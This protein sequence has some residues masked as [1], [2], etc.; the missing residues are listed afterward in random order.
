MS[1]EE[2]LAEPA[3]LPYAHKGDLTQGDIGRHLFNM[4]APMI[5]GLLAVISIQLADTYFISLLGTQE[6]AAISFTFPVT[7]IITHLV[8]GLNIALSSVISRLLGARDIHTAQ[9]VT[10]HGLLLACALSFIVALITFIFLEPL[11]LLLGA[12]DTTMPLINQFM[13]IWL[14]GSVLLTIPVISNSAM[15]AAGDS[16][17]PMMVMALMALVNII[18]NPIL[19]FGWFGLPTLGIMGSAVSTCLAYA[20]AMVLSLY[21]LIRVKNLLPQDGLYLSQIGDS[22]RRL[23]F[24]A[25]PAGITNIVQPLTNAVITALLAAHGAHAVAAFGVATRVEA[26]AMLLV[27]A[28]ALGLAPIVG[29]NWGA[30]NFP[31]VHRAITLSIRFNFFWSALVALILFVFAEPV[32]RVF[33]EDADVVSYAVWYFLLVPVSYGLSNLVFGWGAAFNAMGLPQWSF[34]MIAVKA[35]VITL[36]AVVIG[37]YL[38]D[39]MGILIALSLANILSGVVFHILSWRIC[40][41]QEEKLAQ[42]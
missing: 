6:L 35:F 12:D 25:I 15:R 5:G 36:P 13:P 31:R 41:Q 38:G 3:P 29:Q 42:A 18:L 33:S 34:I 1:A 10:L 11:F 40:Y 9:R 22:F 39:A 26:L 8:F 20:A 21:D 19:I 37:S 28:L 24:I 17:H 7:M 23:I 14:A 16:F 4:T 2:T 30:R 27:I 32:A